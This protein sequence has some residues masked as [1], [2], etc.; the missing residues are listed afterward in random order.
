M[1]KERWFRIWFFNS[2]E[3]ERIA[4]SASSSVLKRESEVLDDGWIN[5]AEEEGA[6]FRVEVGRVFGE[7]SAVGSVSNRSEDLSW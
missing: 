1:T 2:V 5:G 7:D 4:W 3:A 6:D